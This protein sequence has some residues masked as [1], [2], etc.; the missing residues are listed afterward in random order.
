MTFP[1]GRR[2][3]P[4]K[5]LEVFAYAVTGPMFDEVWAVGLM[6]RTFEAFGTATTFPFGA[7]TKPL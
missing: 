7:R 2:T 5:K 1:D 3:P 6:T 4:W